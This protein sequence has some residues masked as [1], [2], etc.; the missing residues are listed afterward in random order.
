T[1]HSVSQRANLIICFGAVVLFGVLVLN[2]LSRSF[3][4]DRIDITL[5]GKAH[6]F[7]NRNPVELAQVVV[8]LDTDLTPLFN[9]NT[10][11]LFLYITAEYQTTENVVSQ[12]VIWDRILND[13]TKAIIN[14]KNLIKYILI[15]HS[16]ELRSANITLTFNYNVIPISGPLTRHKQGSYSFNMPVDYVQ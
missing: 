12:V 10:K 9:W 11:M 14:E 2:V 3:F 1:M 4:P 13:K 16:G 8:D 6:K 15:D 7:V 5:T